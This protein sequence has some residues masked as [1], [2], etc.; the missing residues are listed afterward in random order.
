MYTFEIPRKNGD[1]CT[2][3][4]RRES[5]PLIARNIEFTDAVQ[6]NDR[7]K[8]RRIKRTKIQAHIAKPRNKFIICKNMVNKLIYKYSSSTEL[9][10]VSHI[11][12]LV[13]I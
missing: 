11:A 4:F 8:F 7:S 10:Q 1:N 3:Q 6:T 13:C 12:S 5:I 2:D 9:D